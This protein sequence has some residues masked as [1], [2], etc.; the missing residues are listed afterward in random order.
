MLMMMLPSC[1]LR[2]AGKAALLIVKV[3]IAS[4][5]MTAGYERSGFLQAERARADACHVGFLQVVGLQ[6]FSCIAIEGKTQK[7][8]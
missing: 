4:I 7:A 3:P 1:A 2:S 8:Y 6:E 5:S